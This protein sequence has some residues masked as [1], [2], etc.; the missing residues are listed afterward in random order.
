MPREPGGVLS[1]HVS[2]ERLCRAKALV[3]RAVGISA[4]RRPLEEP[5][6]RVSVQIG[7]RHRLRLLA[8]IAEVV[9]GQPG[10]VAVRGY[11]V[12]TGVALAGQ[13]AS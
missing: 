1:L 13:V 10:R 3:G 4:R 2:Y 11:R 9:D 5:P 6:G 8:M 12:G 7:H